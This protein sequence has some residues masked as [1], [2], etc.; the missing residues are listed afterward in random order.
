[1]TI[2]QAAMVDEELDLT[3]HPRILEVHG[4]ILYLLWWP[5]R[6]TY[7]N[8]LSMGLYLTRIGIPLIHRR[9]V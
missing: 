7:S 6:R 8:T 1:M 2:E 5:L 9:T 3:S 4:E